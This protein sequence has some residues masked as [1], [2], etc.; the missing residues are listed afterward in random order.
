[1]ETRGHAYGCVRSAISLKTFRDFLEGPP[2]LI[3]IMVLT[4]T[5][6]TNEG[7]VAHYSSIIMMD[8]QLL[9]PYLLSI[10]CD[11]IILSFS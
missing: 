9:Y 3:G 11:R 5:D 4:D 8:K 6:Q 1:M 2:T 10:D 7:V